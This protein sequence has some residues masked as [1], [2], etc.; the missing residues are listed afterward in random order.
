MGIWIK[1]Q[2]KTVLVGVCICKP[3]LE[4]K[5]IAWWW[6]NRHIDWRKPM[7][8]NRPHRSLRKE[9]RHFNRER[10]IFSANGA[11]KIGNPYAKKKK[12]WTYIQA[13]YLSQ[14]VTH[15]SETSNKH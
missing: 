5:L 3:F 12:K 4:S 11:E 15:C 7:E 9:Q 1:G 10:I 6:K 8:L 14:K 13:L 2:C